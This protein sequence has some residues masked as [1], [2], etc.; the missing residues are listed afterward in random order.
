M[1]QN[2]WQQLSRVS[3]D[4]KSSL[5]LPSGYSIFHII[6]F[7]LRT[8]NWRK[9]IC[10]LSHA[11]QREK[12][13]GGGGGIISKSPDIWQRV[14]WNYNAPLNPLIKN[15][16]LSENSAACIAL[17]GKEGKTWVKDG[18]TDKELCGTWKLAWLYNTGEGELS[19]NQR[20]M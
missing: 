2:D 19:L 7:L 4:W 18:K 16:R 14:L 20:K 8:F 11:K 5:E 17:I 12:K 6:I 1:V 9:G 3:L 10:A 13:G 15:R